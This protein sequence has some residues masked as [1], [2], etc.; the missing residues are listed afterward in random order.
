MQLQS[1][2]CLVGNS[3]IDGLK[4]RLVQ[5]LAV[6]LTA[7]WFVSEKHIVEDDVL[8][9]KVISQFAPVT[10]FPLLT[11][12]R[13][14]C[15]KIE[16]YTNTHT[17]HLYFTDNFLCS[18]YRFQSESTIPDQ[19]QF[20]LFVLKVQ[21]C[22]LISLIVLFLQWLLTW[23]K[24]VSLRS[25]SSTNYPT[26][27]H[28]L[29]STFFFLHVYKFHTSPNITIYKGYKIKYTQNFSYTNTLTNDTQ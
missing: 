27:H 1:T 20:V 29:L 16:N 26:L 17:T 5:Y 22:H 19:M 15:S 13:P 11:K 28:P 8:F 6:T 10:Y 18:F 24:R 14:Q 21:N 23:S 2:K 9:T 3:I 7:R 25:V 4:L 12:H